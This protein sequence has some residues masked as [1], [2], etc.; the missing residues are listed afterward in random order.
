MKLDSSA[1]FHKED[2]KAVEASYK[3]A[4]LIAKDKKPH[5]IG[6]SLIKP[7]L[8][9]ACNTVFGEKS[10]KKVAKISL[11]NDTVKRRIDEMGQDLKKQIIEKLKKS[12]FFS[13]MWWDNRHFKPFSVVVL[14]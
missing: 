14:L 8:L 11:S 1:N 10:C 6:E 3:I 2:D 12:P 13:A 4:L 5:T 7:C 9:N